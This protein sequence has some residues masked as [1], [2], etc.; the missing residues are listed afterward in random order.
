[1][2]DPYQVAHD[3]RWHERHLHTQPHTMRQSS[4]GLTT[5]VKKAALPTFSPNRYTFPW[6]ESMT[7]V[8]EK[9]LIR[10]AQGT[11]IVQGQAGGMTPYSTM[12]KN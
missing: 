4:A 1:M 6:N 9:T 11:D 10:Q 5:Q 12:G 7:S 3:N 2:A 8:M